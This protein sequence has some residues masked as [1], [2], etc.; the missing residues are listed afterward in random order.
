MDFE[1]EQF[2]VE[3]SKDIEENLIAWSTDG[4]IVRYV[5]PT[6]KY[7]IRKHSPVKN[8]LLLESFYD[9]KFEAIQARAWYNKHTI[10]HLGKK[11][12]IN[13]PDKRVDEV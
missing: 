7:S 10:E 5:T 3:S 13:H 1:T 6:T 2:L 11:F 8:V 4:N 12:L 9:N